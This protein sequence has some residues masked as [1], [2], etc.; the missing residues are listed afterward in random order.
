MNDPG[1]VERSMHPLWLHFRGEH[2]HMERE[3]FL[4]YS[5]GFFSF[6]FFATF[7]IVVLLSV[8]ATMAGTASNVATIIT[9]M[10]M[11]M[12]FTFLVLP[13]FGNVDVYS[14]K[15]SFDH[16]LVGFILT[17]N[18]F[19]LFFES[20]SPQTQL[21]AFAGL[22]SNAGFVGVGIVVAHVMHLSWLVK[23][24]GTVFIP[25]MHT[26]KPLHA[27]RGLETAVMWSA[28]VIAFMLGYLIERGQ[29][30]LFLQ[31]HLMMKLAEANRSADSR[32][33]HVVKG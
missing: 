8:V 25:L 28:C 4:D 15:T 7:M 30:L 18:V 5:V 20:A 26:F 31:H 3:L 13:R 22:V 27:E 33:N 23:L 11:Q 29:R 9:L 21:S 16:S 14:L 32:L 12:A 2:V 1:R 24:S 19:R 6:G 10:T 17:V